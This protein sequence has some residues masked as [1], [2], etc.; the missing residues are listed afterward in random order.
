MI[1][2]LVTGDRD[3]YDKEMIESALRAYQPC[4][5]IQGGARGA[6]TIADIVA[7]ELGIESTTVKANWKEHGRAAGPIRNREML[8]YKPDIV[9][10][11]HNDIISSKGTRDMCRASIKQ[12]IKVILYSEQDPKGI[13][14]HNC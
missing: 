7:T 4:S 14:I 9:L 10:A 6:D 8:K 12:G 11:F 2:I 1:K 5:L 3:W 13:E